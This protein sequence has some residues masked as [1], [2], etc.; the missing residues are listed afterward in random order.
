MISNPTTLLVLPNE[1]IG[2]IAEYLC[3]TILLSFRRACKRLHDISRYTCGS[4]FF[5]TIKTDL[6]RDSLETLLSIFGTSNLSIHFK[7]FRVECPF[8]F[9]DDQ[10]KQQVGRLGLGY[11]WLR[12]PN[13]FLIDSKASQASRILEKLFIHYFVNCRSW[14]VSETPDGFEPHND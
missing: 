8:Y 1:I 9:Y 13:G 4:R 12:L 3:Q 6:S 5:N 11:N 7:N 2:E 10:G 14:S